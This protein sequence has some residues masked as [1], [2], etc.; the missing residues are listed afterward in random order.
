MS[1]FRIAVIARPALLQS[2]LG[3]GSCG[4]AGRGNLPARQEIAASRI[5]RSSQRQQGRHLLIEY[6]PRRYVRISQ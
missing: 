4:A 6:R 5:A 2:E 3:P 1:H